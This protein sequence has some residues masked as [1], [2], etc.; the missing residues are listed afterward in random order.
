MNHKE[1]GKLVQH[2]MY[3]FNAY[4]WKLKKASDNSMCI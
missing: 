2:G 3:K 4:L 1:Q